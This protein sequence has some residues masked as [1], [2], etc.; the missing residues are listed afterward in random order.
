MQFLDHVIS[1]NGIMLDLVKVKSVIKCIL[2]KTPWKVNS[3]LRLSGY[4]RGFIQD[5]SNIATSLTKLTKNRSENTSPWNSSP[6][7]HIQ[8]NI[9]IPFR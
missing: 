1:T 4:Y 3:F 6:S 5:F 7:Y 8:L 9:I 2:P